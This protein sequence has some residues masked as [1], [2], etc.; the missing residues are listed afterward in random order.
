MPIFLGVGAIATYSGAV[1]PRY[2]DT[3]AI[4]TYSGAVGADI[5]GR[6]ETDVLSKKRALLKYRCG[7]EVICACGRGTVR[8]ERFLG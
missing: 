4:A 2:S 3:F 5:L 7:T 1:G 8:G 6:R